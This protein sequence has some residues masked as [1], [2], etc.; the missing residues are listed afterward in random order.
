VTLPLLRADRAGIEAAVA[1]LREGRLILHPTETVPSLTGDPRADIAVRSA[2]RIKGYDR[3]RPLL[4]L[5]AD[6]GAAREL[7]AEWPAAAERLAAAFWPGPLTLVVAGGPDA[8]RPVLG[9]GRGLALR[10]AS[11]PVS[12]DLLAAWGGPLFSTSANPRGTSPPLSVADAARTLAGRPGA[13]AL[14][15]GLEPEGPAGSIAGQPSTVVDARQDPPRA[16]RVGAIDLE[17]LTRVV[18]VCAPSPGR[19]P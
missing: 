13:E 8:P 10:P 2:L 17:R 9:E 5:V 4:C 1:A 6:A 3:R 7:A 11:D 16:V 14:A 12:R 15:L 18:A 19:R